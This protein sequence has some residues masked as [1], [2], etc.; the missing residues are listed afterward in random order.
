MAMENAGF[1]LRDMIGWNRTN[2]MLKAQQISKVFDRRNDV[3]NS[4]KF[5]E[6]RV[7]NLRP[8]FEPILWFIKPYKQGG[9]IADNMLIN[10]TGA[11]NLEKWKKY[12]P[13]SGNYIEIQNLSSDRGN[14]PTQ[15][16]LELMKALIELVTQEGQVVLDPF[17]GSGTTLLAAKELERK[18]IGFEMKDEFFENAI[19]RLENKNKKKERN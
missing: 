16:P 10:G 4:K 18:Y 9:T 15:K 13:N 19:K 12:S 8:V 17:A 5:R 14:H 3:E 6:W 1:V 2:A 11:Y 7:G